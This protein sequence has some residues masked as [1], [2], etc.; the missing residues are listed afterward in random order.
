VRGEGGGELSFCVFSFRLWGGGGRKRKRKG[1]MNAASSRGRGK[2]EKGYRS[3][4]LRGKKAERTNGRLLVSRSFFFSPLFRGKG[5]KKGEGEKVQPLSSSPF[6][7][8]L[9]KKN[10][11]FVPPTFQESRWKKRGKKEGKGR[12]GGKRSAFLLQPTLLKREEKGGGEK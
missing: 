3:H 4:R 1:V 6:L 11:P 10:T 5:G 8:P 7:F 12:G 9:E 2:K